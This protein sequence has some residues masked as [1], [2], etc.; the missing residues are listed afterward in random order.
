MIDIKFNLQQVSMSFKLIV[1]PR[2]ELSKKGLNIKRLMARKPK[3]KKKNTGLLVTGFHNLPSE[4]T[5]VSSMAGLLNSKHYNTSNNC[6][7][8]S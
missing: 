1:F 6:I 8:H 2:C 3:K 7:K 4:Y 5:E